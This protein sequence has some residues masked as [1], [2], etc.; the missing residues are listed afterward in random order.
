MVGFLLKRCF[1][2]LYFN[3]TAHIQR[4]FS[5]LRREGNT[6]FLGFI[7]NPPFFNLRKF[8]SKKQKSMPSR[9]DLLLSLH[10]SAPTDDFTLFALAKEYEGLGE[11]ATAL[12]YYEK[13][14]AA[15]P[16][17]VGVYYHFG[18]LLEL[19]ERPT[20]ALDIYQKG[21]E[22]AQSAGDLHA[23]GELRGAKMN[24]EIER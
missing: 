2:A 23:A 10:A 20:E 1:F 18:K 11:L 5:N 19:I 4:A 9:L 22:T 16:G 14:A 6:R 8:I 21:I 7:Q 13:L 15:H 12:S 17:Y 3:K 24:L